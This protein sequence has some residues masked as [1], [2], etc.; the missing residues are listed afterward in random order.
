MNPTLKLFCASASAMLLGCNLDLSGANINA[1]VDANANVKIDNRGQDGGP[2]GGP[3]QG[4]S[5]LQGVTGLEIQADTETIAWGAVG[6]FD[7]EPQDF[8]GPPNMGNPV[9]YPTP[10]V[11]GTPRPMRAVFAKFKIFASVKNGPDFIEVPPDDPGFAF[12][13]EPNVPIDLRS[14]DRIISPLAET[15]PGQI[16]LRVSWGDVVATRKFQV[17]SGGAA[18]V[19]AE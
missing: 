3:N 10:F 1:K 16:T 7:Q 12:Q 14:H 15:P 4:P 17:V 9:P 6:P 18:D 13:V 2:N 19:V 5:G 8:S 11:V